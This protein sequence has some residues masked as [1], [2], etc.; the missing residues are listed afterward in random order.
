[1]AITAAL[2]TV[3]WLLGSAVLAAGQAAASPPAETPVL[4]PAAPAAAT[5]VNRSQAETAGLAVYWQRSIPLEKGE[6]LARIQRIEENLYLVTQQN[7]VLTL[8]AATGVFRWSKTLAQEG[9]RVL[10]PTHGTDLVY[11]ASV[12]SIQGLDRVN[13]DQRLDWRS[14]IA[15]SSPITSD[16]RELYF[17]T[18]DGRVVSVRQRDVLSSW[19]FGTD[20]LVTAEPVLQGPNL[21]VVSQMGQVLAAVQRNKTRI[22][23]T[24]T[25]GP[26]QGAPAVGGG[27][28]YV[29]SMDQSLWCFD[30][31]TGRTIWRTRMSYPLP[32]GP[33]ATAKHLYLPVT[34]HG[35]FSIDPD[36]GKIVWHHEDA[37]AYLAETND[38]VWLA[39]LRS[40]LLGC[41]K[42]S[43]EVRREIAMS[44]SLYFS[45]AEDDAIWMASEDGQVICLRPQGAGFLRYRKAYEAIGR[46]T[47][48]TTQ[49][50]SRPAGEELVP[51]PPPKPPVDYLRRNEAIP[52]VGGNTPAAPPSE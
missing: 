40:S 6:R 23:Q 31:E 28:L 38:L 51:T 29:A 27:H 37:T 50:T 19:Q 5:L 33:H 9:I 2:Q 46:S 3:G 48:P 13:G 49:P 1:M 12:L 7:R 39:S 44:A 52:P 34:E 24:K 25:S 30:L 17:G 16:G 11:F 35:L 15:P 42:I 22:W 47:P 20:G 43:G 18:I 36:D 32:N 14:P 8:D 10:G 41:D 26:V 21:Y 4:A 45:N